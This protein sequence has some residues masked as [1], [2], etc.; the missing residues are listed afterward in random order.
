MNIMKQYEI[1]YQ[2][3]LQGKE[4]LEKEYELCKSR[5]GNEVYSIDGHSFTFSKLITQHTFIAAR[6]ERKHTCPARAYMYF[7][8]ATRMCT[9]MPTYLPLIYY[10]DMI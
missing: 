9:G 1:I 3:P 8:P 2:Q 7:N 10:D 4:F 6:C 5:K